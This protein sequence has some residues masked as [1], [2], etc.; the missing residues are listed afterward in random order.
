MR[1]RLADA[2]AGTRPVKWRTPSEI[3]GGRYVVVGGRD[4]YVERGEGS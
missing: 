1:I 4:A 3:L 2:D